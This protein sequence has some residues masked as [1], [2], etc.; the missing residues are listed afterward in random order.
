MC[1]ANQETATRIRSHDTTRNISRRGVPH[2][3][4]I[5]VVL[6]GGL[7]VFSAYYRNEIIHRLEYYHLDGRGTSLRYNNHDRWRS[8]QRGRAHASKRILS[9]EEYMDRYLQFTD[10]D[11]HNNGPD[12]QDATNGPTIFGYT[13]MP[14]SRPTRVPSS[15]PS[16]RPSKRP[17]ASPSNVPSKFPSGME[18]KNVIF[19]TVVAAFFPLS[20]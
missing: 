16:A 11:R 1:R 18:C 3:V 14:S 7:V 12:G 15:S 4:L 6:A 13:K 10:D 9:D 19:S 20:Q 8:G 17:S 2:L 5:F